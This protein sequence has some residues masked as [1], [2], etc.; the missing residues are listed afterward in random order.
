MIIAAAS[1][2]LFIILC[3]SLSPTLFN[4]CLDYRNYKTRRSY[5]TPYSKEKVVKWC[6]DSLRGLASRAYWQLIH[7]LLS[8][9]WEEIHAKI[10]L[11]EQ[12]RQPL[13]H[14]CSHLFSRMN[15]KTKKKESSS[16]SAIWNSILFANSTTKG[17]EIRRFSSNCTS[18]W[19]NN[20]TLLFRIHIHIERKKACYPTHHHEH[21]RKEGGRESGS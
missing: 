15:V 4:S 10:E 1:Y 11:L 13:S 20:R 16:S 19:T 7:S 9:L 5:A 2:N 18:H 3:N 21:Q 14:S 17:R 12:R 6:D 8:S